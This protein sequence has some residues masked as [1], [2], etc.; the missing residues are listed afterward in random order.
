MKLFCKHEWKLLFEKETKS[1]FESVYSMTFS[2]SKKIQIPWQMCNATKKYIQ[3]LSCKKCG[4]I[5]K[6]VTKN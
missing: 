2:N 6:F 5:K 3:I 4:K 1:K